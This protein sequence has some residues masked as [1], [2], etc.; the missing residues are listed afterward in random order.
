MA[1]WRV[2][3]VCAAVALLGAAGSAR[4]ATLLPGEVLEVAFDFTSPAVFV[5]PSSPP[6]SVPPD[7]L[8][9]RVVAGT[10]VGLSGVTVELF[11]GATGLGSDSDGLAPGIWG[12]AA[13]SSAWSASL[14][15]VVV[16]LSSV[17][18]GSIAGLVR[19]TPH[20]QAVAGAHLE[21]TFVEVLSGVAT[22]TVGG[23]LRASPDPRI[24]SQSVVLVPEPAPTLLLL[25]ALAALGARARRPR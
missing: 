22:T 2:L 1:R 6:A 18:D 13:A 12:F 9:F 5:N 17:V 4:S 10:V 25:A 24:L 20:F 3:G 7:V 14:N 8:T 19:L 21:I 11:D 15:R 16:D 23:L